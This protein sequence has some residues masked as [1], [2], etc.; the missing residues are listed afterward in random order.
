MFMAPRQRW[1][2]D[3]RSG[4]PFRPNGLSE[5]HPG[6]VMKRETRTGV[7]ALH[8]LCRTRQL[9]G[10]LSQNRKRR[11]VDVGIWMGEEFES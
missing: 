6:D 1:M 2:R 11:E 7:F 3:R 9:L 10:A 5:T 4:N 8:D